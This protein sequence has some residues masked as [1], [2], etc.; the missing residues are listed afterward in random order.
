MTALLISYLGLI[1]SEHV[2]QPKFT[3]TV[4][5]SVQPF[6]DEEVVVAG[7]AG[8]FDVDVASGAQLDVVGLWVGQS[9]FVPVPLTGVYFTWDAPGPGW[10][11]GS[12]QGPDD[13]SQ[14]LSRLDDAT[15]RLLLYARIEANTWD[16]TIAGAQE[17]L[18]DL[19]TGSST[20]GT[21]V[22]VQDNFDMTMTFVISGTQPSAVFQAIMKQ[23]LIP[24]RPTGVG[25]ATVMTSVSGAPVF[26]WAMSSAYGA[27]W[28]AGAWAAAL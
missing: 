18:A 5:L 1:T 20:P 19:F 23:G 28:G 13:P 4:T 12:W 24:L 10:T 16:G 21:L 22:W 27:G 7:M 14:G 11:F 2:D 26:A 3:A 6:V 15:Y 17:A 8:L 9:R 25:S